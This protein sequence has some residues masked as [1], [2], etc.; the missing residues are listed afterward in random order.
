[1]QSEALERDA[2]SQADRAAA[3]DALL[4]KAANQTA[5]IVIACYVCRGDRQDFERGRVDTNSE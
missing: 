4:A 2:Q 5:K 1:M 3:V